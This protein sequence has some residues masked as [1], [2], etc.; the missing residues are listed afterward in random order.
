MNQYSRF[1]HINIKV[2]LLFLSLYISWL[3]LFVGIRLDHILFIISLLIFFFFNKFTRNLVIS[4]VFFWIFW[5][6]Y[7]GMRV[8]PNYEFNPVHIIE[9]YT[10]ELRYFGFDYLSERVTINEYFDQNNTKFLDFL[11][12]FFYLTWVPLP[13][14]FCVFLFF[15]KKRLLLSFSACFLVTNL[16]GFALYYM[17]PAAPPWYVSI[18]GFQENFSLPGNAA[19]LLRFDSLIGIPIFENMYNKNANVFAAIPSLH[20]AYP[21]I[22]LYYGTKLKSPWITIIFTLDVIGIW[23]SALYSNHHYMID[24]LLGAGCAMIGI[25][26][27]EIL[28]RKTIIST[29]LDK[30]TAFISR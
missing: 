8:F 7:D 29:Y 2:A 16:V 20:A 11:S 3:L 18:Y 21:V 24:I 27:F 15:K 10:L 26:I 25:I 17:Y 30:L 6:L 9:P 4:L 19:G 28:E 22:L 23:F 14:L 13:M 1:S 12:G 5:I